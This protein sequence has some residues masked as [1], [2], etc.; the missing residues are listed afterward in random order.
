MDVIKI[1][2]TEKQFFDKIPD[3]ETRLFVTNCGY[4]I[5]H[6]AP[7]PFFGNPENNYLL[8][9]QHAG[10]LA[11]PEHG[12]ESVVSGGTCLIFYPRETRKYRFLNDPLNERYFVYFQGDASYFL[13]QFGIL[14]CGRVIHTGLMPDII[15]HFRNIITD[16]EVS[17]YEKD[18]YR[19][20]LLLNIFAEI[21]KKIGGSARQKAT[22]PPAHISQIA[23]YIADSCN[24]TLDLREICTK[25]SISPATLSRQ[26]HKWYSTSPMEYYNAEKYN[27][28]AALLIGSAL[29]ISSIAYSLGFNDP[30]YFSKFFKKRSGLYPSAFRAKNKL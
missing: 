22:P 27:K 4:S 26:F 11:I 15:A 25:F 13:E 21:G 8:L 10:S 7:S 23:Q 19:F 17:P 2:I 24:R 18:I 9:Y 16:F 20:T 28:A 3:G 29:P 5:T 30:L 1:A 14:R 6:S 12:K